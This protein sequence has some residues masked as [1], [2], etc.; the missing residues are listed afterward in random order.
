VKRAAGRVLLGPAVESHLATGWPGVRS[1]E[2][3][4]PG[5]AGLGK[6][7]WSGAFRGHRLVSAEASAVGTRWRVVFS[8]AVPAR[9][10]ERHEIFAGKEQI[11]LK[12]TFTLIVASPFA[13]S[14]LW[15]CASMKEK[16]VSLEE[17]SEAARAT[18]SRETA[19]G[20]IESILLEKEHGQMVYDVEANVAGK[21]KEWTVAQAD[22][23]ILGTEVQ[24]GFEELPEAVRGAAE[25]FFGGTTG[26]MVMRGEEL[27]QTSY[28]VEG[29][30][31]GRK[32]EVTFDPAGKRVE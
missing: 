23:A 7:I 27:G 25:S 16:P 15:G 20:Q 21:H 22:G 12:R 5:A 29:E 26:L 13:L 19:G 18:V 11:M 4:V 10:P 1:G 30:R 17:L 8:A 6:K 28:E 24:I 32:V 14:L 9:E 2:A 31:E 3:A